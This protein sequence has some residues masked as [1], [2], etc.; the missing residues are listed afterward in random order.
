VTTAD[1]ITSKGAT[2]V[3]VATACTTNSPKFLPSTA[4]YARKGTCH[5]LRPG[6]L[7]W[8]LTHH[9][10]VYVHLLVQ[11]EITRSIRLKILQR[12]TNSYDDSKAFLKTD[13]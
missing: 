3:T 7:D 13:D 5:R 6:E 1:T 8:T 9:F 12:K 4:I 11:I 10:K 2:A